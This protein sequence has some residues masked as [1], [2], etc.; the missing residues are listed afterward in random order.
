MNDFDEEINHLIS[1]ESFISDTTRFLE[2]ETKNHGSTPE[3]K[4]R[5][6]KEFRELQRLKDSLQMLYDKYGIEDDD[7]T[8]DDEDD[9]LEENE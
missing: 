9:T 5:V 6:I 1:Q 7:L 2:K 4:S 3:I 8:D